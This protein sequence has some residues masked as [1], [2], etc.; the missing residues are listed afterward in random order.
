MTQRKFKEDVH[1]G[2]VNRLGFLK[3]PQDM[4]KNRRVFEPL[5]LVTLAD[6]IASG[7]IRKDQRK[8][9]TIIQKER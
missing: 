4:L 5:V 8:K 9:A 6:F 7:R 3:A 2:V 1:I